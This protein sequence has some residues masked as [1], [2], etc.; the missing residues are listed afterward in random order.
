M[1]TIKNKNLRL[2]SG[3]SNEKLGNLISNYLNIP[4]LKVRIRRFCKF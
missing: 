1:E 3:K 2:I 4:L